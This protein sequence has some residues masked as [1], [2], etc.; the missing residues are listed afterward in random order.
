MVVGVVLR[1]PFHHHLPGIILRRTSA[2]AVIVV[3]P[4]LRRRPHHRIGSVPGHPVSAQLLDLPIR[5]KLAL[6]QLL[7]I[8]EL[9]MGVDETLLRNIGKIPIQLLE[10]GQN[11]LVHTI[12]EE[13][14]VQ[15]IKHPA[16]TG[17]GTILRQLL[18]L[19]NGVALGRPVI[20]T[21]LK[22]GVN[23]LFTRYLFIQVTDAVDFFHRQRPMSISQIKKGGIVGV[24]KVGP[25]R[26]GFQKSVLINRQVA[27]IRL[28]GN[29]SDVV[30]Q[31]RIG[32]IGAHRSPAPLPHLGESKA[33]LPHPSPIPE[34]RKP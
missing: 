4:L 21:V 33:H 34:S 7:R 26:S 30:V 23:A 19:D 25:S 28:A 17:A 1:H 24:H 27:G 5:D 20:H 6:N 29:L 9:S 11:I 3:V 12:I 18:R 22:L 14:T 2:V 15:I 16:V 31:T 8:A 32:G 13:L 10:F